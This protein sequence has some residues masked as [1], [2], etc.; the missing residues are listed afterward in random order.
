MRQRRVAAMLLAMP[1]VNV[2]GRYAQRFSVR[3]ADDLRSTSAWSGLASRWRWLRRFSWPIFRGC[4]HRMRRRAACTA[5]RGARG[6]RR[7]Q[8]QAAHLCRHAD[9]RIVSAA[10]RRMRADEDAVSCWS[11]R[12]RHSTLANVLAVNLPVMNYGKTAAAGERVLSRGERARERTAG[13]RARG[14]RASAYRGATTRAA[15]I[16]LHVC[17]AGRPPRRTART[18]F[19]RSSAPFRRDSLPTLGVPLLAGPRL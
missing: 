19:V 17:G 7:K 16:S 11:R 6:G 15:S 4:L 14:R 18:S 1:M 8:P 3:A 2:L 12:G 13:R 9:Y 5:A 10:G